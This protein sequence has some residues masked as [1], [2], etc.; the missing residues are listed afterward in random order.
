MVYRITIYCRQIASPTDRTWLELA[1]ISITDLVT[2][3]WRQIV[4]D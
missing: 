3:V 1:E 2:S 4:E